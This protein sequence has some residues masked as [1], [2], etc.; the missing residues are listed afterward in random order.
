MC[1]YT[2]EKKA[3]RTKEDIVCYKAFKKIRRYKNIDGTLQYKKSYGYKLKTFYFHFVVDI[4][5]KYTTGR[6]IPCK[7]KFDACNENFY[8]DYPY[9]VNEDAFHSFKNLSELKAFL[10]YETERFHYGASI[11]IQ[12]CIIHSVFKTFP[13]RI[14]VS[15]PFL[16]PNFH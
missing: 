5:K 7:S 11:S 1:L 15:I 10:N 16:H 13:F 14:W 9:E 8:S 4:G 6:T 2:K 12:R 3:K